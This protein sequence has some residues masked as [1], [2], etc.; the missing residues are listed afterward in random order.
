MVDRGVGVCEGV[1]W[2]E[3]REDFRQ[4]AWWSRASTGAKN[5]RETSRKSRT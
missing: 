3:D 5:L 2:V 4:H 1:G